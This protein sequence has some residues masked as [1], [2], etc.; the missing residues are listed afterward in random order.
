MTPKNPILCGIDIGSSKV[1]VLIVS[2]VESGKIS[3][4]GVATMPSKGI[5]KG[6]M[7]D[8]EGAA[9]VIKECLKSAE[10][11]AG[12]KVTSAFLSIGGAHIEST[13]THAVVAISPDH[14]INDQDLGRLN[15]IAKAVALPSSREI[16]HS[17]P[18]NYTIDGQTGISSPLEM[19]GSRLETD[20]HI[21]CGSSVAIS[22]LTKCMER[23]GVNI[24]KIIFS[25]IAS[26]ESILTETEKELGVVVIDLGAET[27]DIVIIYEGA[28]VYS[29]VIPIGTKYI[30]NDIAIGLKVTMESAESIKKEIVDLTLKND[31]NMIIKAR[32]KEI[33]EL[34]KIGIKKSKYGL[35]TPLG[36]VVCGGGALTVGLIDQIRRTLAFPARI[37][38]VE[39]FGGLNDEIN[40]PAFATA[41][42]LILH[43]S[44]NQMPNT[45]SFFLDTWIN[46]ITRL[47]KS[48]LQLP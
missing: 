45:K 11:M 14:D 38:K 23:V 20:T 5:K 34:V 25:G 44:R 21:V 39:G 28:V 17:L 13:N 33:L 32:V 31:E 24:E 1:V 48:L 22:N 3:V 15:E 42:G 35:Q 8:I 9:D 19:S 46:K 6:Q 16:L 18:I 7:V 30:T 40:S 10:R 41:A 2:V 36:V 29:T 27:V 4:L 37:G 43:G 47:A 12:H 26:A